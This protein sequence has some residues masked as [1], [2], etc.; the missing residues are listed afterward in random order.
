M[1]CHNQH[2]INILPL[3]YMVVQIHIGSYNNKKCDQIWFFPAVKNTLLYK[4]D[5]KLTQ[6]SL[7]DVLQLDIMIAENMTKNH[8]SIAYC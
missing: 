2:Y 8:C 3:N 4:N 5:A 7:E 1:V 6:F